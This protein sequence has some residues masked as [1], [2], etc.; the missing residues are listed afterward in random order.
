MLLRTQTHATFLFLDAPDGWEY[1]KDKYGN[2]LDTF[3]KSAQDVELEPF[4]EGLL[5]QKALITAQGVHRIV[6]N[7]SIFYS[8]SQTTVFSPRIM[9]LMHE[10]NATF[11][12]FMQ[13][14]TEGED[15]YVMLDKIRS[16]PGMWLGEYKI[17]LLRSFIDGYQHAENGERE[18]QPSFDGFNDFIGGY[19]GKFTTPGWK[20]LILE[21]HNGDEEKALDQFFI[22]LDEFR[23]MKGTPNSR[24]IVLRLLHV[25]MLDFRAEN[26][27]DR[28]K[29]IADLMHHV[30]NQ[31]KTA[32]YCGQ[33]WFDKILE[34]VF[35]R[36][37]GNG[38]LHHWIK[39]NAPETVYYE[40]EL[41]SGLDENGIV[42]SSIKSGHSL[43]NWSPN[44][45]VKLIKTFFA[46]N[47]DQE[48]R[49]KEAFL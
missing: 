13:R 39:A 49:V 20:N 7:H 1:T 24:D 3:S 27:H 21:A 33:F 4:L 43:K 35:D 23:A 38:Y 32:I 18:E 30:S 47:T 28:Q 12:I 40:C 36:A 2:E 29:Q 37:H 8:E 44:P 19:Y 34:D 25:A 9:A 31:L 10:L 11:S 16:R 46:I 48:N 41:W 22:F 6:V 15:L 14:I 26:D 42:T 17:T 45:N 5:A